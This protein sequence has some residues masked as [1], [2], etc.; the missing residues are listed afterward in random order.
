MA[1]NHYLNPIDS[2]RATDRN[3][4]TPMIGFELCQDMLRVQANNSTSQL[5]LGKSV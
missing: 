3:Q 5:Q 4:S 1:A 2:N